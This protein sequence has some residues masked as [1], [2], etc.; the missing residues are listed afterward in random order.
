MR[1]LVT[2]LVQV[3]TVTVAAG[4]VLIHQM[5]T[6]CHRVSLF[7]LLFLLNSHITIIIRNSSSS[8]N[9]TCHLSNRNAPFNW[10]S[11]V[12]LVV[13]KVCRSSLSRNPIR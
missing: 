6:S 10:I 3:V 9:T 12:T 5:T 4:Q 7:E 11:L 13:R 1:H 8:S 2:W